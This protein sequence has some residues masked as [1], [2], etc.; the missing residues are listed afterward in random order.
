VDI[1][2]NCRIAQPAHRHGSRPAYRD[3]IR[4]A[5]KTDLGIANVMDIRV[6]QKVVVNM[7]VRRRGIARV[8]RDSLTGCHPRPHVADHRPEADACARLRSPSPQFKLRARPGYWRK[9]HPAGRPECGVPGPGWSRLR[10]RLIR[11]FRAFRRSS[12][13]AAANYTFGVVEQSIFHEID[14]DRMTASVAWTSR[15]SPRPTTDDAGT[16]A[17]RALGFPS[18]RTK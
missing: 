1:D 17:L 7:G 2:D 5:L 9:G 12:S 15:S 18:G 16:G 3:E 11:D 10:S 8:T 6:W 14:Q 4:P 13:T